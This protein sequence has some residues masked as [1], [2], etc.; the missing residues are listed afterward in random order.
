MMG[1]EKKKR[2]GGTK[3]TRGDNMGTLDPLKVTGALAW[4]EFLGSGP[5]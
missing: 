5:V 1:F 2:G 3:W 4:R